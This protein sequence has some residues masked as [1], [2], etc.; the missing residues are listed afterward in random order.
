MNLENFDLWDITQRRVVISYQRFETTHLQGL[1]FQNKMK[2]Y[3][4]SKM[5]QERALGT[6]PEDDNV[7]PKHVGPTIHN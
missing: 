2:F 1:K 3:N 5:R 6:L 4:F 7:N